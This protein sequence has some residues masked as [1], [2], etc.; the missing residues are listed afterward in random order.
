M[1]ATAFLAAARVFFSSE[2]AGAGTFSSDAAFSC[3]AR[4]RLAAAALALLDFED[5]TVKALLREQGE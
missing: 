4:F 5:M 3:S 1:A 2:R